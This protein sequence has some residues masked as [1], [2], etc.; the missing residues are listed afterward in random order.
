MGDS[1]P[2]PT[3]LLLERWN[4]D[5]HRLR[6]L[7]PDEGL[8]TPTRPRFPI[9]VFVFWASKILFGGYTKCNISHRTCLLLRSAKQSRRVAAHQVSCP[10]SFG[11]FHTGRVSVTPANGACC[12]QRQCSHCLQ[13]ISKERCSNLRVLCE[14]GLYW[15]GPSGVFRFPRKGW[16]LSANIICLWDSGGGGYLIVDH[17]TTPPGPVFYEIL[18]L[19]CNEQPVSKVSLSFLVNFFVLK[20]K[21]LS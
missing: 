17:L 4:D 13:A 21:K 6:A 3:C 14:L 1:A 12:F 18:E 10:S 19:Q 16:P 15:P 5:S 8:A 2:L 9:A 11:L 7:C 20:K